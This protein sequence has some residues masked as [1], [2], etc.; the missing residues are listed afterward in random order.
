MSGT[1]A[2]A[3][4]A[5]AVAT[6][7]FLWQ[8]YTWR[9]SNTVRL[10]ATTGLYVSSGDNKEHVMVALT[11]PNDHPVRWTLIALETP[12]S[13][14]DNASWVFTPPFYSGEFP[15]IIPP[16]DQRSVFIERHKVR[17]TVSLSKPLRFRLGIATGE[18]AATPMEPLEDATGK[19]LRQPKVTTPPRTRLLTRLPQRRLY[20]DD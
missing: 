14:A 20:D 11:N 12:E 13:A 1:T 8:I 18:E 17:E 10:K 5:S 19:P 4:Y 7:G 9:H 2:L 3:I 6:G 15:T 16:H